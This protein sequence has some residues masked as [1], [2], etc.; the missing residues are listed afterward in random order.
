MR[1]QRLV[2]AKTPNAWGFGPV[3]EKQHGVQGFLE[4]IVGDFD[5]LLPTNLMEPGWRTIEC[6]RSSPGQKIVPGH[7]M[8]QT[9]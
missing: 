2:A 8:R 9:R 3:L 5:A 1:C 6:S 7:S 4:S